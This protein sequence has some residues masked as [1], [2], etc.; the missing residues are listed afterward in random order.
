M[1]T[2]E[3]IK[4]N[5][6]KYERM[7]DEAFGLVPKQPQQSKTPSFAQDYGPMPDIMPFDKVYGALC[8][9][10]EA[11]SA[12][13]DGWS[14]TLSPVNIGPMPRDAAGQLR[15]YI[16]RDLSRHH[17]ERHKADFED[18]KRFRTQQRVGV[19]F[20][21]LAK[22]D[23]LYGLTKDVMGHYLERLPHSAQRAVQR[24]FARC[25]LEAL[26]FYKEVREA[27]AEVTRIRHKRG[28][29]RA[30]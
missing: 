4:A 17:H 14:D 15:W 7:L 2:D 21:K 29:R 19:V 28:P 13:S 10:P 12:M 9:D 16:M 11:V 27:A 20:Q 23:P 8:C 24:M 26:D 30:S 25:P 1:R 22:H 6:A 3:E 5:Q 18:A